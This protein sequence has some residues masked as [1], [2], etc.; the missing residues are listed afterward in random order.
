MLT[1]PQEIALLRS[2]NEELRERNNEI[3][4][5]LIVVEEI[6]DTVPPPLPPPVCVCVCLCGVVCVC[7]L[8]V[9]CVYV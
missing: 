6:V 5:K 4:G 9:V 1:C 2:V 3:A 7:V 8:G